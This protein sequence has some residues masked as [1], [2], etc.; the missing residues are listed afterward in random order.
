MKRQSKMEKFLSE[1]GP[2]ILWMFAVYGALN[3][4]FL[5]WGI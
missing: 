2:V 4:I 5:W 1:F 3:L